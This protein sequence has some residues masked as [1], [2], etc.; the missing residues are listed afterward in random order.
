[1]SPSKIKLSGSSHTKNI[2]SQADL[3]YDETLH[4]VS[5]LQG[6]LGRTSGE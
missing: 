6:A 3:H 4:C 5:C 2:L 1:M